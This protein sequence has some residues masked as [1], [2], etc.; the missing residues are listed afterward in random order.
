CLGLKLTLGA[1]LPV[2]RSLKLAFDAT[3]S[4]VYR[5]AFERCKDGLRRGAS[6]H[7]ILT[8]TGLFPQDFLSAVDVGEESGSLPEVMEREAKNIQEETTLRLKALT[9]IAGVLLWAMI[10]LFIIMMIFQVL[11]VG[12]IGQI[13]KLA[14]PVR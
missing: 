1:G 2:K 10:A 8:E 6:I 9:R 3:A 14:D 11:Q 13:E 12:Y 7:E 4:P 5:A